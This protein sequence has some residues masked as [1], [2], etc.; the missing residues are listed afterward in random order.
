MSIRQLLK[1]HQEKLRV[2]TTRIVDYTNSNAGISRCENMRLSST[3]LEMLVVTNCCFI[4]LYKCKC[5][6][7]IVHEC[8]YIIVQ[9]AA[10]YLFADTDKAKMR[11]QHKSN[12][13]TYI[14]D[15][16]RGERVRERVFLIVELIDP[17]K[18][19]S[20]YSAKSPRYSLPPSLTHSHSPCTSFSPSSFSSFILVSLYTI[21]PFDATTPESSMKKISSNP[22]ITTLLPRPHFVFYPY[23]P[24]CQPSERHY[25]IYY[26]HT[27]Q[28]IYN[29]LYQFFFFF[30]LFRLFCFFIF[31]DFIVV[32]TVLFFLFY[33]H[34]T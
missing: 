18:L 29:K 21:S 10:F 33:Y 32:Y 2:G 13:Y 5:T 7:S 3:H 16:K 28:L 8:I 11:Y 19:I 4:Y 25:R 26:C 15:R 24:L 20:R 1:S 30:A 27:T 14:Q 12:I 9:R 17:T 23:G 22:P 6:S 31:L 34:Y